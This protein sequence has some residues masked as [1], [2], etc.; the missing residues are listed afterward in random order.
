[1]C[2]CGA[3]ST[4]TW[5]CLL[6]SWLPRA[7]KLCRLTCPVFTHHGSRV[8]CVCCAVCLCP[9]VFMFVRVVCARVRVARHAL[10]VRRCTATC[11]LC[12]KGVQVR[13]YEKL[14]RRPVKRQRP[15]ATVQPRAQGAE[16]C[17]AWLPRATESNLAVSGHRMRHK[18][19]CMALVTCCLPQVT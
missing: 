14:R 8:S 4:R 1:M 13:K 2:M 18:P 16:E 11:H 9:C 17:P 12:R 10:C 6:A 7:R 19:H 5:R 15:T 3:D